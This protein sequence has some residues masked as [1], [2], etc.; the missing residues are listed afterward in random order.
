MKSNYPFLARNKQ[1]ETD[2]QRENIDALWNQL[3]S[4]GFVGKQS[5]F[6]GYGEDG[7]LQPDRP[8]GIMETSNGPKTVHEGEQGAVN[9]SGNFSITPANKTPQMQPGIPD[10]GA[11][12]FQGF[13]PAEQLGGQESLAGIEKS[14][15]MEGFQSG[16]PDQNGL[17]DIYGNPT[18]NKNTTVSSSTPS[19]IT[20]TSNATDTYKP[21]Q[22]RGLQ[23][24]E[25]YAES[26]SPMDTSIM[27]A[28]RDRFSGKAASARGAYSQEL[29]QAGVTGREAATEQFML[30]RQIG[31]QEN[32]MM[33]GLRKEQSDKAFAASQQLPGAA[34]TART[35]DRMKESL[36]FSKQQWSD[37]EGQRMLTDALVMDE[38][39]WLQQH[40]GKTAADYKTARDEATLNQ[41]QVSLSE[42]KW[43]DTEGQRALADTLSMDLETW[44]RKYPSMTARDYETGR[45]QTTLDQQK[46][47]SDEQKYKDS[48]EWK[49]Y[50]AAILAGS[51]NTA[52][53]IYQNLTGVPIDT[54]EMERYQNYLIAK[55]N[56]DIISG[57]I[58]ID[59]QRLGVS[60]DRL[61]TFIN[62]VN[63]GADLTAANDASGLN[64]TPGQ[65]DGI[66]RDYTAAGEQQR[67]AIES[68]KTSLGSQQFNDI[69]D[70]IGKGASLD[71]IND[72]LGTNLN[73][74]DYQNMRALTPAGQYEWEQTMTAASMLMQTG[75]PANILTAAQ[76]YGELFPGVTFDMTQLVDD[77]G[78]ERFAKGMSDMATVAST[79]D[80]WNDALTTVTGLNL[81]ETLGLDNNAMRDLFQGLKINQIDEE[82]KAIED[83][84]YYQTLLKEDPDTAQ[85]IQDTFSAGLSGE[86]EFDIT[87]RYDVVDGNGDLVESFDS[88]ADANTYLGENA[89]AGYS[90]EEGKNY[91]YKNLTSGDTVV[92]NN[93]TGETSGE[94]GEGPIPSQAGG[95]TDRPV[96]TYYIED[97]RLYQ[98]GPGGEIIEPEIDP[99]TDAWGMVG[100]KIIELGKE[101]NPYYSQIIDE[102]A[103][104]IIS[105]EHIVGEKIE[106]EEL[107]AA[108]NSKA[109][110]WT[111]KITEHRENN[112]G[113]PDWA[114]AQR[115]WERYYDFDN[116]PQIDQVIKFDGKALKVIKEQQHGTNNPYITVQDL[117]D[118][119][120]KYLVHTL[121]VAEG[122][123]KDPYDPNG[124]ILEDDPEKLKYYNRGTIS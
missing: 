81:A 32:E 40:P 62:A 4:M 6:T 29:S 111:P 13:T 50:E 108:V 19:S 58:A 114:I 78:A 54:S 91:V 122:G 20:P 23:R 9:A 76:M 99:Y 68:L 36:D 103:N 115:D 69:V 105:G 104:Q 61:T 90:I 123:S 88:I 74:N 47:A 25:R 39:S 31:S 21:Y 117:S 101:N 70:R 10:N 52:A 109:E 26:T 84:D 89:N 34:A 119:S 53:S 41:R 42:Q 37:T 102:R 113:K 86:L 38:G 57:D 30:G 118:G 71:Q 5:F 106:N 79:F 92:V 93:N 83:S 1:I 59:A 116:P 15:G 100:D 60:T 49:A 28:E 77:I 48:E 45:N 3:G 55:Q 98:V 120:I 46:F 63:N 65:F 73:Y 67:L 124:I 18:T 80:N 11:G 44:L 2:K 16:T 72:D 56:Q 85:L 33:Q 97:K 121:G 8:T 43:Q 96:G 107:L 112:T 64:L 87:P 35:E 95:G 51:F 66:A 22:T 110:L 17:M 82:W 94:S 75:S 14:T 27:N 12:K 7:K 24:L